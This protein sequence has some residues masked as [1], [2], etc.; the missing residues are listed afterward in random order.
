MIRKMLVIAAA[1][2]VPV[3]V[4][5][6]TGGVAGAKG[7][8]GVAADTLHCTTEQTVATFSIPFS[9]TGVTSGQQMT[10][11]SGTI[12]NCTVSGAT[13][14]AGT[15]TGTISGTLISGK[16][17]SAKHP[18]G[19]CSSLANGVTTKEKGPLTVTWSDSSDA[20]VNGM[21][22]VTNVK[23][24]VGGTITVGGTLYGAFTVNGKAAKTNLFQGT[25]KGKS[26]VASSMTD[27]AGTTLLA[28]CLSSGLS[29]I[30]LQ[31]Q[32][33]GLEFS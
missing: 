7:A 11:I 14:V 26:S 27:V 31:A 16:P 6:A 8:T 28:Q 25:D 33:S 13:P 9:S 4:V 3:S 10:T 29:S 32:P 22:S 18:A 30:S 20:A 19:V 21:H 15:V 5:A 17:A 24:I 12:S 2:A 23:N 1:I